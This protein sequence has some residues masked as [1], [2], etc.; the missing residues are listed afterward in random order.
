MT[1]N[2]NWSAYGVW[3]NNSQNGSVN[4]EFHKDLV[5]NI[6]NTTNMGVGLVSGTLYSGGGDGLN[7]GTTMTMHGASTVNVHG[8]SVIGAA[9]G[10]MFN[11]NSNGG[12]HLVFW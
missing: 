9:A 8:N 3:I 5:V 4:L 7:N 10:S 1:S 11:N 12:G 2:S 6:Q